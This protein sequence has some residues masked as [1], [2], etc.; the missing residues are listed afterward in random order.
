MNYLLL[1]LTLFS[2]TT[3][4]QQNPLVNTKWEYTVAE[5]CVNYILFRANGIYENYSCEID[6]PFSGTYELKGGI[7]YFVEIDLASNLPGETNKVVKNRM[8][9]RVENN[10]LRF[11]DLEDFVDGKWVKP[12]QD[13][14]PEIFYKKV[15]H[16][17]NF[18]K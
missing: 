16:E 3:Q 5:G 17:K 15:D 11:F 10:K 4:E 12:K 8:K 9:G 7:I 18:K 6:Y 1:L 14:I 13:S 2:Y